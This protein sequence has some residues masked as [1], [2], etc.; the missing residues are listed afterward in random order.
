[1]LELGGVVVVLSL[2][3]LDFLWWCFLAFLPVLP[4]VS[5]EVVVEAVLDCVVVL[6]C[7]WSA[8][9]PLVPGVVL[10]LLADPVG[11]DWLAVPALGVWSSGRGV[12]CA[13]CGVT[14]LAGGLSGVE[15]VLD[16]LATL[17]D[18]LDVD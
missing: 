9:A 4:V 15:V 11:F 13:G 3:V 6:L 14:L 2:L 16:G 8:T 5:A 7:G 18:G 1:V 12:G 17:L 10:V